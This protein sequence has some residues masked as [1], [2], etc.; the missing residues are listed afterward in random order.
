MGGAAGVGLD[1]GDEAEDELE[2]GFAAEAGAG[3]SG[4]WVVVVVVTV[5]VADAENVVVVIGTRFA[6]SAHPAA[7][8]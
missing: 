8:A 5:C 1:D 6:G 3:V 2:D 4:V 7:A